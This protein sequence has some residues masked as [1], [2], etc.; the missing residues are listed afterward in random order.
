MR[1]NKSRKLKQTKSSSTMEVGI[2]HQ[3]TS[4]FRLMRF[5]VVTSLL[6]NSFQGLFR[7]RV[8]KVRRTLG[9]R[10]FYNTYKFGQFER[11]S[12]LELRVQFPCSAK[13][14]TRQPNSRECSVYPSVSRMPRR[15]PLNLMRDNPTQLH[16]LGSPVILG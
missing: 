12:I 9:T 13:T 5:V 4:E 3:S 15:E 8:H 10:L 2:G 6:T 11:A 1:C 16:S 14:S 7:R